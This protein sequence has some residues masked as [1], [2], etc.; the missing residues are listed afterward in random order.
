MS[1][2]FTYTMEDRI[3]SSLLEEL[4]DSKR[5]REEIPNPGI[6]YW[7]SC[8]HNL[9]KDKL[10][11]FGLIIIILMS[12][13]AI[14]VPLFSPY[15]YDQIDFNHTMQWPDRNHLF[16]TDKLG[17]DIFVRTMYGARISLSIG[18]AA[19]GINMAIGVL[20]GGIAGYF[21]G[22]TDMIMMRIVDILSSIPSMLYLILIM[23]YLGNSIQSILIALCLTYWITTARMVRAQILTLKNLDF[24]WA[25]K[26]CGLTKWQIVIKHFIPNSMGSIIVSVTFVIPS[27]IFQ[28]AFLSFLGIGIQIPKASWGTL[29]NEG[30]AYLFTHPYQMLFPAL[31][32][33]I[34]IFSLNFLGD[35]LRDALDPRLKKL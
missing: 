23:M 4:P 13:L 22:M 12:L 9:K 6:S 26:V 19:A 29:A 1:K 17:R 2:K 15:S 10:A 31:C 5:T 32:I 3:P 35:G 7:E 18:F 24:A 20:Y 30:M 34:T 8:R 11:M 27:A 33:S 14:L 28:E 25:A 21:G 16:G